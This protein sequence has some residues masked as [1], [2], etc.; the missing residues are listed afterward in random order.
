MVLLAVEA[1]LL[2]G[3]LS[4]Y[5]KITNQGQE[6]FVP[7]AVALYLCVVPALIVLLALNR[8]LSNLQNDQVFIEQN[9]RCLRLI[10]W[11]CFVVGL[12][13]ALLGIRY[14]FALLIAIAAVFVALILRVLKNVFD[15]AV[16]IKTENDYTI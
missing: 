16:R 4:W 8:L 12:V 9:T 10:S 3:Q 13:F 7:I 15:Y 6:V 2:P 5:L 11:C 14:L 1:F